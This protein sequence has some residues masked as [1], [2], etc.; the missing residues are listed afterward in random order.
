MGQK[1]KLM[2]A[3]NGFQHLELKKERKKKLWFGLLKAKR[4]LLT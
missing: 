2:T 3:P 4:G 1:K